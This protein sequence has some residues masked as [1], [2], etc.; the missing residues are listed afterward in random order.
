[1]TISWIVGSTP[2]GMSANSV[3]RIAYPKSPSDVTPVTC[4]F[5]GAL[6][7][8]DNDQFSGTFSPATT[9][10]RND[11]AASDLV[12]IGTP[13]MSQDL[14]R[15]TVWTASGTVGFEYLIAITVQSLDGQTITRSFIL[16][17]NLR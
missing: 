2:P 16:P 6:A 8:I 9:V 10:M 3:K 17:V 12:V 7:A 13:S 14:T 15:V 11:G 1:M 5:S 4:D